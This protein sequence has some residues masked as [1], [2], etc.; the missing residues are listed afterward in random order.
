MEWNLSMG[1]PRRKLRI[2]HTG[3]AGP[4]NPAINS[5]LDAISG[6]LGTDAI[7]EVGRDSARRGV[8]AELPKPAYGRREKD[9]VPQDA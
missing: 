4:R 7:G 8:T 1:N 3:N 2:R 6:V 9:E 5:L